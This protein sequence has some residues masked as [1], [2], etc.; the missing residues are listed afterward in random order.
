[1]TSFL[2]TINLSGRKSTK[3]NSL[4]SLILPKVAQDNLFP[5]YSKS[6]LQITRPR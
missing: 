1:M 6:D 4:F 5:V 2:H 3:D